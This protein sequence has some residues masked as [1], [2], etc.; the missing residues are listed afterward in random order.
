MDRTVSV[1]W[2]RRDLKW[3]YYPKQLMKT[4][5]IWTHNR[6]LRFNSR[7][8]P[9]FVWYPSISKEFHDCRYTR[10]WKL[11]MSL[12][13]SCSG[14]SS[15]SDKFHHQHPTRG[16]S[17][18]LLFFNISGKVSSKDSNGH[19]LA[20]QPLPPL[21]LLWGNDTIW[22][23]WFISTIWELFLANWLKLLELF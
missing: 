6:I 20:W 17:N 18:M 22:N 15:S 10:I 5:W 11:E 3:I 2:F 21:P 19:H 1:I 16:H 23:S 14:T 9:N 7:E 4:L 13:A 8:N 12:S